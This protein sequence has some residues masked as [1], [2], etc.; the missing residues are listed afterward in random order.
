MPYESTEHKNKESE[1]HY[2]D[3]K[4][5]KLIL[6]H[7]QEKE[8]DVISTTLFFLPYYL[9]VATY[10]NISLFEAFLLLV[11]TLYIVHH[12]VQQSK[13][14]LTGFSIRAILLNFY[15]GILINLLLTK[16]L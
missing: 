15:E 9:K 7:K 6:S 1:K 13:N 5:K 10:L 4:W 16:V 12:S 14:L 11:K 2:F 8:D 3:T